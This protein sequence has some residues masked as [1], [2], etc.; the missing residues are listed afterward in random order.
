VGNGHAEQRRGE[1]LLSDRNRRSGSSTAEKMIQKPKAE[2]DE[3][4]RVET[5]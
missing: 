2:A 3:T 4:H 5:P 1:R